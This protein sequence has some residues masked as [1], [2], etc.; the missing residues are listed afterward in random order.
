MTVDHV[1]ELLVGLQSLPFE[2]RAPVL[3]EMPGP[4]LVLVAPQLTERLLEQVG[5]VQPLVGAQQSPQCLAALQREVLPARQQSVFLPLD[6]ATVPA[7]QPRT[8]GLAHLIARFP[9]G[10]EE[11]E[12]DE[13][14]R[15]LR[16]GDD[17]D[18]A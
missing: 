5:G 12:L 10:T 16:R 18:V 14:N 15:R 4:A 2:R 1:G 3:E 13:R 7:R 9:P 11:I 17:G 8:L 6:E